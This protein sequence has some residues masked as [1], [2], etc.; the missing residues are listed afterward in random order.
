MLV[1]VSANP[2][3]S[4][5]GHRDRRGGSCQKNQPEGNGARV[6]WNALRWRSV[7]KTLENSTRLARIELSMRL[8]FGNSTSRNR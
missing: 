3:R 7:R 2:R 1:T 4:C 8:S 6:S 5:V